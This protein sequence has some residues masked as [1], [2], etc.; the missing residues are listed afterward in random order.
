MA[1]K[2]KLVQ[3]DSRPQ[4]KCVIMDETTGTVVNLAGATVRLKFKAVGGAGVLF[5]LVGILL[6]G[7]EQE[8]ADL[9]VAPPYD[10]AGIGGRV[11]FQFGLT[12]LNV[13]PGAY[14]GEVEVTFEDSTVQTVFSLLRFE[15]RE[16]F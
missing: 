7:L 4:I 5:T 6:A 13:V 9:S 10:V 8:G 14:L 15:V 16:Q 3:G 2:I 12:D 1:Q 11:A